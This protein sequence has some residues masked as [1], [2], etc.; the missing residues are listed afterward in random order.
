MHKSVMDIVKTRIS[1]MSTITASSALYQY[2]VSSEMVFTHFWQ[3]TL[4]WS[5]SW[6]GDF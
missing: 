2:M 3:A 4:I 1:N 6:R 5:V